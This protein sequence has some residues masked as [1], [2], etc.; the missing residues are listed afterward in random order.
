MRDHCRLSGLAWP[1]YLSGAS[2]IFAMGSLLLL[3]RKSRE[4]SLENEQ[5]DPPHS[6]GAMPFTSLSS[7]FVAA[8]ET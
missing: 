2:I 8:G 3:L 5:V 1:M 7:V 4:G 6:A